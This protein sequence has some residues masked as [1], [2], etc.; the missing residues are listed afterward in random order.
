[1]KFDY[2]EKR[3]S[4]DYLKLRIGNYCNYINYNYFI[5]SRAE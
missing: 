1:M 2:F 5:S 3:K 4:W